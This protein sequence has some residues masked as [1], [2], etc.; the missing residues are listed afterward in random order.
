[1]GR[2]LTGTTQGAAVPDSPSEDFYL[3]LDSL[4]ARP[5]G[6]GRLEE[7]AVRLCSIQGTFAP[8]VSSRRLVVFAAA[9]CGADADTAT[10]RIQEVLTGKAACAVLAKAY[11]SELVLIDIGSRAEA[12]PESP[13]YRSRKIPRILRTEKTVRAPNLDEFRA[14]FVVGQTEAER[15]SRDGM[16][17]IAGGELDHQYPDL[18]ALLAR[19]DHPPL[20]GTDQILAFSELALGLEVAALAGLFARGAE[21]GLTVVLEGP[22]TVAAALIACHLYPNS[23]AGLIAAHGGE[24]AAHRAALDKLGLSPLLEGWSLQTAEGAGGLLAF[25]FLDAAAALAVNFEPAAGSPI[26]Q[27]AVS[28]K[29]SR[30]VAVFTGSFDPPTTFHRRVAGLVRELGFDEVIVRPTGPRVDRPDGEHAAP[31]HRAVMVDL[32][33]NDLPGVR[34]DLDD[35]DE[36][37]VLPDYR[38]DD[39]YA[40][41]GEVWHIVSA[42]F[43]VGGREGTS[44]IHTR[45]EKGSEL[46]KAGRFLV[47]HPSGSPPNPADLPPT[48]QLLPVDQ[49]VPTADIRLRVFQGGDVGQDVP[50]GVADYIRRYRLFSDFPSPRETRI[51]LQDPRLMIVADEANPK[52]QALAEHFRQRESSNPN[53]ILVLGG[54][55]TLLAAIRQHWRLRLPFI[56]LNA[57]NLGFLLNEKL[58]ESLTNL[59]LVV[60]RMPML[61]VDTQSPDGRSSRSLAYVDAWLERNTGQA[62]WLRVD[63]DGRTQ[64]PKVVGDGLLVATPAGSSAYA[65]AMGATPVPI[66]APVLTLAGSNVF[67]PRFWKP[68]ALPE[69]AVVRL[70]NLDATGKRSIRGFLDGHSL[71]A[72]AAM[73]V[74]VSSIAAVELAFTPQFDLSTRLV[75]SL[76]PPFEEQR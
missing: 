21:L 20:P 66:T 37:C 26:E 25:P 14:A 70:T 49:H 57:G 5:T 2:N 47:L 22:T 61:R 71:G 68:V 19:L 29:P 33:F 3:K 67:R 50:A 48:H 34:V 36:G 76:F 52:A 73:E 6:L 4:S 41:R 60:Y 16:K 27:P 15:A 72:V 8:R 1:M 69:S 46:W 62:A 42:D 38:F 44:A 24:G 12:L 30:R 18:E 7:L 31:L 55:G 58:P 40:D 51:T 17:L 32:A 11:G 74:R 45:W 56:G 35:L 39:L 43:L 75:R 59:E 65:R 28:L 63:I 9:H 64:V 10:A 23:A 13:N 54:D 53:A